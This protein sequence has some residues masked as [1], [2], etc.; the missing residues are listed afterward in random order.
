MI[1]QSSP[2]PSHPE[3]RQRF[4]RLQALIFDPPRRRRLIAIVG[5][6]ALTLV[7]L[8]AILVSRFGVLPIDLWTTRELQEH[9]LTRLMYAVSLFGYTPWSAVTVAVGTLLVGV[10]LGWRDGVFLLAVTV[11][12][13]LINAAVKIAIGRPRPLS[14]VVDVIAPERGNSFPSG[15]VMFYTVFFGFLAFLAW[16]R[17]PRSPLRW[18]LIVAACLP[19]ALIGVSRLILGAH[20]LSDVIAAY[21]LGFVL[22]A[23]AIEGYLTWLAPRQPGQERGL[24]RVYDEQ[25]ESAAQERS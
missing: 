9:P 25:Q 4:G 14:A 13:G 23:I 22:L 19:V 11:A 12:Q 6:A 16:S 5:I 24:V 8:L 17:M 3:V 1:N 18:T 15:H 2:V 21:L 20:W 10:L 7:S